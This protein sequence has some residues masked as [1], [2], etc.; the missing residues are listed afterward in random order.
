MSELSFKEKK[1]RSTIELSLN[2]L[3]GKWKILIIWQLKDSAKRYGELKKSLP[4]ATHK[5][6]TQQLRELEQD[7]II[8]RKVY[9]EI[10]PK[11]EYSLT[12]LGKTIIPVIDLLS[13]W[14]EEY[15]RVF[16]K[17]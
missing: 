4:G 12:L 17:D 5:M 8:S 14:G 1:F 16:K 15:R 9:S 11:V 6:L 2:I 3:G 10:P 7:E 13:D